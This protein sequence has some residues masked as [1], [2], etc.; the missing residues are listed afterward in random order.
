MRQLKKNKIK[1]NS[2]SKKKQKE[3]RQLWQLWLRNVI[4]A[5][6]LSFWTA[7]SRWFHHLILD[8]SKGRRSVGGYLATD[9]LGLSLCLHRNGMTKQQQQEE[10]L[11]H[12]HCH[13]VMCKQVDLIH[14]AIFGIPIKCSSWI[15]DKKNVS[16]PLSSPID[17][18]YLWSVACEGIQKPQ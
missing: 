16:F 4:S 15:E 5:Q 14:L 8:L 9:A 7:A 3:L 17:P 13:N 12:C 1:Q 11:C 10:E 18:D 6:G 2:K